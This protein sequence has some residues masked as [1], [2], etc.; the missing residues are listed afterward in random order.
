MPIP[1]RVI[2][3]DNLPQALDCLLLRGEQRVLVEARSCKTSPGY[4]PC[5]RITA[6]RLSAQEQHLPLRHL[7]EFRFNLQ[8]RGSSLVSKGFIPISQWPMALPFEIHLRFTVRLHIVPHQ[9]AMILLR[10]LSLG[11]TALLRTVA[12]PQCINPFRH[13]SH[14]RVEQRVGSHPISLNQSRWRRKG[15]SFGSI[16]TAIFHKPTMVQ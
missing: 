16:L 6:E 13:M 8:Y 12:L 2:C 11:I 4:L 14:P 9:W 7:E 3:G 1:L 10:P 15:P 5:L